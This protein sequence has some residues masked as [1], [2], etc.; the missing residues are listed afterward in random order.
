VVW[1]KRVVN[2]INDSDILIRGHRRFHVGNDMGSV[3]VT[4]LGPMHLVAAPVGS[5]LLAVTRVQVIRRGD[6]HGGGG[7]IFDVAPV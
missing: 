3:V 1:R 5:P 2:R 4:C 6:P 7:T